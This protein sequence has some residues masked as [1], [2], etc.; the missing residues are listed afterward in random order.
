M[1]EMQ[2]VQKQYAAIVQVASDSA[3]YLAALFRAG[4]TEIRNK[5]LE[6]KTYKDLGLKLSKK[7]ENSNVY[8]FNGMSPEESAAFL[9]HFNLRGQVLADAKTGFTIV[10][11]DKR[12]AIALEEAIREMESDKNILKDIFE[13]AKEVD[14]DEILV[15]D[16]VEDASIQ[17]ENEKAYE[18]TYSHNE[19]YNDDDYSS[20]K[21]ED[22]NKE[23]QEKEEEE[24]EEQKQDAAKK[25]EKEN[26]GEH[27]SEQPKDDDS[28]QALKD[29]VESK[30]ES[31]QNTNKV[32]EQPESEIEAKPELGLEPEK[33]EYVQEQDASHYSESKEQRTE[34]NSD[35]NNSTDKTQNTESEQAQEYFS[36]STEENG[37]FEQNESFHDLGQNQEE[38]TRSEDIHRETSG[39][40]QNDVSQE[41]N[42]NQEQMLHDSIDREQEFSQVYGKEN[43]DK[44]NSHQSP[45]QNESHSEEQVRNISEN[46]EHNGTE[47]RT[48]HD[49]QTFGRDVASNNYKTEQY[50]FFSN[51]NSSQEGTQKPHQRDET[52]NGTRLANENTYRKE[53]EEQKAIEAR[54]YEK[55]E[56]AKNIAS[57][58]IGTGAVLGTASIINASTQTL[59]EAAEKNKRQKAM[60]ESQIIDSR[61][62]AQKQAAAA[63]HAAQNAMSENMELGVNNKPDDR[64]RRP[65]EERD[66]SINRMTL[67]K[68]YNIDDVKAP[69]K[70][71]GQLVFAANAE[72]FRQSDVGKARSTFS[73]LSAFAS[74]QAYASVIKQQENALFIKLNKKMNNGK[75]EFSNLNALLKTRGYA[76][77]NFAGMKAGRD[78][79]E[80]VYML[81]KNSGLASKRGDQ[82]DLHKFETL[83][84]KSNKDKNFDSLVRAL[85][86]SG[87]N[88]HENKLIIKQLK[89]L[90]S[91]TKMQREAGKL[92]SKT[93]KSLRSI[94]IHTIGKDSDVLN[95]FME[96]Q[97]NLTMVYNTVRMAMLVAALQTK[98]LGKAI[99]FTANRKIFN[100]TT[101]Q[102]TV[103]KADEG[104]AALRK[105]RADKK[106]AKEIRKSTRKRERNE[107]IRAIAKRPADALKNRVTNRLSP[108]QASKLRKVNAA[109][110][111]GKQV[112]S[113]VLKRIN[114]LSIAGELKVLIDKLKW[115]IILIAGGFVGGFVLLSYVI[116]SLSIIMQNVTT[117][118]TGQSNDEEY[119]F[120]KTTGGKV[121]TKLLT[122]EEEWVDSLLNETS[123]IDDFFSFNIKLGKN[124]ESP[125]TYFAKTNGTVEYHQK[126]LEKYVT[127]NPFPFELTDDLKEA[128]FK[129]IKKIDG[130]VELKYMDGTG[131]TTRTSNIKDIL[132]MASVYFAH[133]E[134][135]EDNFP[136][137]DSVFE[138]G[139][140]LSGLIYAL[141][142]KVVTAVEKHTT[143]GVTWDYCQ[144]LF[145]LSHQ[146]IVDLTYTVLPTFYTAA[147]YNN[148]TQ[149]EIPDIATNANK[150]TVCPEYDEGGCVLYDGF[151]YSGDSICL[152]DA[153]GTLHDV[154]AYVVPTDKD[155]DTFLHNDDDNCD[156]GDYDSSSTNFPDCWKTSSTTTHGQT[157]T[158][159]IEDEPESSES[160]ETLVDGN[161]KAYGEKVTKTEF[162]VKSV[163]QKKGTIKGY[164]ETTITTTEHSCSGKHYGRFCG[165][166]LK[167]DITGVIYGF[168]EEQVRE[169]NPIIIGKVEDGAYASQKVDKTIITP[170]TL[171]SFKDIFDVDN[172]IRHT[173]EMEE[174][175]GWTE[176]NMHQ[177]IMKYN[178]DWQDSYGVDFAPTLGGQAL[179]ASDIRKIVALIK[180]AYPGLSQE[181]I[182]IVTNALSYVGKMGYS[183]TH[184]LCPLDGPCGITGAE[185]C[186]LS[187]C[188]GFASYIWQS[189]L[190]G[191][192]TTASFYTTF[193]PGSFSAANAVPGDILLHYAGRIADG[194]DDHAL[195]WLG[196]FDYDGDGTVE[197]WSVD[198]STVYGAGNVFFR[199]RPYYEECYVISP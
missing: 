44:E 7:V 157:V 171:S 167:A 34:Q 196:Y 31:E 42:F 17:W 174:W 102:N 186:G 18:D 143:E 54:M 10:F 8:A 148:T 76:T 199:S 177:A 150:V 73:G 147:A 89:E 27:N 78:S 97:K 185:R 120:W 47:T 149:T 13:E 60:G 65:L 170:Y 99:R 144:S 153:N 3:K 108:A 95:G 55:T 91:K 165:G 51:L 191:V 172:Y 9:K 86:L 121:A 134:E 116:G 93:G 88:I 123:D 156:I 124:Y 36:A 131:G 38:I 180:D 151:Y 35:N 146:E 105:K 127:G 69:V 52:I 41:D 128:V 111:K 192:Y 92:K 33:A 87:T 26:I 198:C 12:D 61:H 81:L 6:S 109:L 40:I 154:T 112:S 64:Y 158:I 181:R 141:S 114:P 62:D 20:E 25:S 176:D 142:Q 183:Q 32:E 137:V 24:E 11:V 2:N 178:S 79:M 16:G 135:A 193:N 85:G 100:G 49:V 57:N 110:N 119:D 67:K 195:I 122:A 96:S 23:I 94:I 68:G 160:T 90:A 175:A 190:G 166:H 125:A 72:D 107:R 106:E 37:N 188:S 21:D 59:N 194:V 70:T 1:D 45:K 80:S 129:K 182:D 104:L 138:D 66:V 163:N 39:D 133:D 179:S 30:V 58:L 139:F 140:S 117:F 169:D 14:L 71:I 56:H 136:D 98:M 164:E 126:G 46:S 103:N 155:G 22:N 184:H 5:R 19:E 168:T 189:R 187:D 159:A 145:N 82:W 15:S 84:K 132:C 115:K 63:G 74:T 118:F 113:S 53:K 161:G 152:K 48:K 43:V 162:I 101:F 77:L 197:G 4:V 75:Q 28:R 173:S 83:L 29:D 50:T 130:G